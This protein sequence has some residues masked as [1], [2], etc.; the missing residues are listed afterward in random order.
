MV[1]VKTEKK[2][3]S[4]QDKGAATV[5]LDALYQTINEVNWPKN[6]PVTFTPI[7]PSSSTSL[8]SPTDA[9][10]A[11]ASANALSNSNKATKRRPHS[12]SRLGCQTC[13]RR[14]VKCDETHPQCKNCQHLE[15]ECTYITGSNSSSQQG[16]AAPVQG[17]LNILD[18]QLFH[19]YTTIVCKTITAAG[20][21]NDKIWCEEV[22]ELAFKYPFLLHTV[23][24]FSATHFARSYHKPLDLVVS[25]H[26]GEA[27]RLLSDEMKNVTPQ[28]LDALVAASILLIL[29][30]LA[31]ASPDATSSSSISPSAWLH[32][33]RGA[34]TILTSI[35]QFTEESMFHQQLNV[36][37]SDLAMPGVDVI[38][39]LECFDDS[40]K[41]LYPVN[42][43]S[44]YYHGLAYLDK[45]F[46]QRYKSDFILRV[47]S[48]PALLD[49]N[50]VAM[51]LKGD[52]WTK[53]IIKVY[54]KLVKSFTSEMKE[55]VWFL[56]GVSRVLPIDM[57]E[58]GGLGFITHAL[59]LPINIPDMG[60]LMESVSGMDIDQIFQM[61][62]STPNM[63]LMDS[64]N[65]PAAG[66]TGVNPMTDSLDVSAAA[67]SVG[68]EW[69]MSA[70]HST[71]SPT[72]EFNPG[73][74][75]PES[76]S[77]LVMGDKLVIQD[78]PDMTLD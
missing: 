31:N 16:P 52:E 36:D 56:E 35:G 28:N 19:H 37:L 3:G 26:R 23:L 61:L 22:P 60:A 57:D 55:S 6:P 4:G 30:S 38:S 58:L 29:D 46:R 44:P 15:L 24:M 70:N 21:S 10:A 67:G 59:P 64:W 8:V 54:Y 1:R 12:K 41:D 65:L 14:R 48:F 2:T 25:G 71:T 33:V 42:I 68:S 40:L 77:D 78:E 74:V 53:Q 49:R 43:S 62:D 39:P 11:T 47:F 13:K 17:K 51:L 34:A 5:P 75:S 45:L 72:D 66:G 9:A 73:S 50:F 69:A 20:I 27:L 7:T 18:I 76:I 32:H 63:S